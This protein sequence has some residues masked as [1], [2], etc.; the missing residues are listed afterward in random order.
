MTLTE[1]AKQFNMTPQLLGRMLR[2]KDIHWLYWNRKHI[3][4]PTKTAIDNGY[5]I[6]ISCRNR[7]TDE[8]T[9]Q[10]RITPHGM[11]TL[12]ALLKPRITAMQQSRA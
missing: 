4:I 7:Q 9:T 10:A 3:N 6:V 5:V 1:V 11:N 8:L 12:Y 2:S